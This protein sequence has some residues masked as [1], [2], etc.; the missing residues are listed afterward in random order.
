MQEVKLTLAK[1]VDVLQRLRRR[2]LVGDAI[3]GDRPVEAIVRLHATH[4]LL[5]QRLI[6]NDGSDRLPQRLLGMEQGIGGD[7]PD[8]DVVAVAQLALVA[9]LVEEL[10]ALF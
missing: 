2:R 6:D 1:T 4:A 3:D 8:L 9:A 10:A 5:P 7:N